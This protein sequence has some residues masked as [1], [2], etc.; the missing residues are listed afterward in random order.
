V[1]RPAAGEITP[2]RATGA[3][4]TSTQVDV[5]LFYSLQGLLVQLFRSS[6]R[7]RIRS[8]HGR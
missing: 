7:Q 2:D 5:N 6:R 1:L 3:D 8:P 4:A